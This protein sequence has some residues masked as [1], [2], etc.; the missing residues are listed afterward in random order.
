VAELVAA[1][2][3][4]TWFARQPSELLP[5]DLR[6]EG[7]TKGHDIVDVWFESG[8]SWAAVCEGRRGLDTSDMPGN[9]RPCIPVGLYL[10]GSDQ[11]SGWFHSALLTSVAT[12]GHA[13]YRAVLTHGFVLDDRGRPY[14]KSEIEKARQQ[15]I[16]IE[17]IPPDEVLKTQGAEL[18]RLWTASSDFRN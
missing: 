14:S 9:G 2:G 7:V 18:L 13:P 1:E 17:F 15:G 10:E 3:V 5:P 12:R 11:H 16:K 4:D 8:G 6:R